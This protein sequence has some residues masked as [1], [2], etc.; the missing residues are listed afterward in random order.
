M[1]TLVFKIIITTINLLSFLNGLFIHFF[2]ETMNSFLSLLCIG[3]S[4][5]YMLDVLTTKISV[6][7]IDY[8]VIGLILTSRILI[9]NRMY[10]VNIIGIIGIVLIFADFILF[11]HIFDMIKNKKIEILS[12][13]KIREIMK[14]VNIAE[15]FERSILFF[16][17]RNGKTFNDNDKN[18]KK[19]SVTIFLGIIAF[20]FYISKYV[21]DILNFDNKEY[22][23]TRGFIAIYML[24]SVIFL[25][26]NII[27]S[28]I[29]E[30]RRI[31]MILI[32]IN[33]IIASSLFVFLQKGFAR[34]QIL[35]IYIYLAGPYFSLIFKNIKTFAQRIYV[36]NN[37][38]KI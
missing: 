14:T 6:I 29:M 26:L 21:L 18:K 20:S 28:K 13:K 35:V 32:S 36:E 33:Y 37:T 11:I 9:L 34:L 27:L 2:K 31:M 4:I 24:L 23:Y 22:T 38:N 16:L 10:D 1:R 19:L 7:L 17:Y 30:K 12:R 8:V 3:L 15:Y 5:L 25:V